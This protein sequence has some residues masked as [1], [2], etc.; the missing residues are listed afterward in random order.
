ME[1]TSLITELRGKTLTL[2]L[3]RP[4]TRNAL[5]TCLVEEILYVLNK[6]ESNESIVAMI[7]TGKG[8]DFCSGRD[9]NEAHRLQTLPLQERRYAYYKI[10]E[11][12][13]KI[14][15]LKIPTIAAVQGCAYAGGFA[16]AAVCDILV[17]TEDAKFCVPEGKIGVVPGTVTPPLFRALGPRKATELILTGDVL[18]S[19]EALGIGFVNKVVSSDMLLET[20]LSISE[21]IASSSPTAIRMW[22]ENVVGLERGDFRSFVFGFAEIVTLM[23]F[24]DDASE[25]LRAF[26]EK[27]R[28]KWCEGSPK[29]EV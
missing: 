2:F 18:E 9:L 17:A 8:K 22:K 21:R 29:L 20:A 16:L 13:N 3:N 10:A 7:I 27:R 5:N 14:A 28:P 23:S 1:L 12:F 11:L 24:S 25:G 15:T 4:N 6:A 19:K 26:V